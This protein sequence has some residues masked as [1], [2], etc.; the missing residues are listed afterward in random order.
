MPSAILFTFVNENEEPLPDPVDYGIEATKKLTGRTLKA[1][2]FEFE[3]LDANTGDVID[4]ATNDENGKIIKCTPD[5]K[6]LT[7]KGWI[8][9]KYLNQSR[10]I[11]D[12]M[13]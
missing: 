13:D 8:K 2:E 10:K 7:D 9:A 1:G 5:H 12:I 11:F 6:I 4:T 3:L